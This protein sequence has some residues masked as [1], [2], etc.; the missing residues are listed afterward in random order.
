MGLGDSGRPR[1]ALR[2]QR[3][4]EPCNGLIG[5]WQFNGVGRIQARTSNFG[6]VRLVGM[7]AKDAQK[8]YKWDV[9][10]D[11]ATGLRTVYTMPDDVILN[12]RRAF[13]GSSTS[14]TGYSDLG[15]PEGRYFAPRTLILRA[16]FFSRFDVGVTK[17]FRVRGR[18]NFELRS[19]LLNVFDNINFTVTAASRTPGTGATIFQTTAAYTD[20]SNTFDPGGRLG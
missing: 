1:R 15:V 3:P 11:P 18:V 17:R 10:I 20:L 6:N 14:L 4:P 12:T 5:G 2:N 13:N 7:T 16:P 8:L 9:R 19:D